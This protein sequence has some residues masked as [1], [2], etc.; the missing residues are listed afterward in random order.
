MSGQDFFKM[1]VL[2]LILIYVCI[3]SSKLAEWFFKCAALCSIL[4]AF[5][6]KELADAK[7][8]LTQLFFTGA[9][10]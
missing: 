6:W 5:N 8:F 7:H 9:T 3:L 1:D 2:N 10:K 4:I